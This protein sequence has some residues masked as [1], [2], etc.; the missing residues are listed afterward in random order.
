MFRSSFFVVLLVSLAGCAVLAHGEGLMPA[1]L[2]Q[3]GFI[4]D[5]LSDGSDFVPTT[6]RDK[7]R[8]FIEMNHATPRYIYFTNDMSL[9]R[10]PAQF[11]LPGLDS[12][13]YNSS[14]TEY[15]DFELEACEWM[16]YGESLVLLSAVTFIVAFLI[17]PI[18][19][20]ALG[21]GRCCCCGRYKPT[22][23]LCCGDPDDFEATTNGY[24]DLNVFVLFIISIVVCVILVI[25]CG[26]G[27]AG[28]TQMTD[29]VYEAADFANRTAFT[30]VD[31]LD[32]VIEV[33]QNIKDNGGNLS[34]AVSTTTLETA[35]DVGGTIEN[36][37]NI[38]AEYVDVIDLPRRILMYI[39]LILPLVLM[40]LLIIS[41]FV[42]WWLSWGMT[43][44]G[45]IITAIALVIFGF[46]YPIANGLSDGCV[47]LDNALENPEN[48]T[49]FQSIFQCNE[50]SPLG[51][52]SKMAKD[53]IETAANL[54][55]SIYDQLEETYLPCDADGDGIVNV[56]D[57]ST[58]NKCRLIK[59]KEGEEECNSSNFASLAQNVT[60]YDR[61]IGCFYALQA[62]PHIFQIEGD[63][64][65]DIHS[66]TDYDLTCPERDGYVR[67]L[68]YC[69]RPPEE[70]T[71]SMKECAENCTD[72]DLRNSTA[73]VEKY[74]SAAARTLQI[75]NEDIEP[76]INCE[77]LVDITTRAKNF[78]CVDVINSVT[79]MYVGEIMSAIGCFIGTF[80]ALLATKRFHK[81]YRRKYA[82]L[83]E[84]SRSVELVP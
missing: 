30:F 63:C 29:N 43:F 64:T 23:T 22:P 49:F 7:A 36:V 24:T 27:L 60:M 20:C 48:D 26:F 5:F 10:V 38:I 66:L 4:D 28:S 81:M 77:S 6:D 44:C 1:P 58:L 21:F 35:K 76:Y 68:F 78:T 55:C 14:N 13:S 84:G 17:F 33:F 32:S 80:V 67:G 15:Q 31:V 54:T 16:E 52:F 19:F 70:T 57:N 46:L 9:K 59:F 45:F 82:I 56:L 42:C 47:L 41:R 11:C 34:E 62:T 71:V 75:Y 37:T 25:A 53:V 73:E 74:I 69:Y 12:S 50:D 40:I 3:K 18:L 72:H 65:S 61:W 39:T 79:P 2:V 51:E 83:M 8:K